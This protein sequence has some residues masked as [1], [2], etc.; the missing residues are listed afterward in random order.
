MPEQEYTIEEI[1]EELDDTYF[2]GEPITTGPEAES[3]IKRKLRELYALPNINRDESALKASIE[4]AADKFVASTEFSLEEIEQHAKRFAFFYKDWEEAAEE[5]L[6][7][8]IGQEIITY[9]PYM[10]LERLGRAI[11]DDEGFFEVSDGRIACFN[12]EG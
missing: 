5:H 9:L 8:M 7:S 12:K 2:E 3:D 10:D 4:Y 11:K 1:L 6:K